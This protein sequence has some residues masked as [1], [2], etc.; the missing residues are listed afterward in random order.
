MQ[1]NIVLVVGEKGAGKSHLTNLLPKDVTKRFLMLTPAGMK[2]EGLQG[3]M[4]STADAVKLIQPAIGISYDLE[5]IL[6]DKTKEAKRQIR[7]I[8]NIVLTMAGCGSAYAKKMIVKSAIDLAERGYHV[9]IECYPDEV[10]WLLKQLTHC[11]VLA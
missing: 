8:E 2:A 10:S 6:V 9:Y 3:D 7:K 11:E 4:K 5:T 1:K